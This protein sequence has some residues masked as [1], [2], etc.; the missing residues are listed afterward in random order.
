MGAVH[1]VGVD[2]QKRIPSPEEPGRDL[3]RHPSGMAAVLAHIAQAA[4]AGNVGVEGGHRDSL[5]RQPFH[6]HADLWRA[7]GAQGDGLRAR[8]RRFPQQAAAR[9]LIL[10]GVGSNIQRHI[11]VPIFFQKAGHTRFHFVLHIALL[12]LRLYQRQMPGRAAG[13]QRAGHTVGVVVQL[14]QHLKHPFPHLRFHIRAVVE[15]PVHGS[16][17][18]AGPLRDHF[19]GGPHKFPSLF[20]LSLHTGR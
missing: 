2:H 4:T 1:R 20:S 9:R 17:G 12:P 18:H 6:G 10:S 14:F 8:I 15:Y 19:D 3:P 11:I 5:I 7:G 13:R 16:D